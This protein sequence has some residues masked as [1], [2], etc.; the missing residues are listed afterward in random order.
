MKK[1]TKIV[2]SRS[3]CVIAEVAPRAPKIDPLTGAEMS[4]DAYYEKWGITDP[5]EA[6]AQERCIVAMACAPQEAS[7]EVQEIFLDWVDPYR[8]DADLARVVTRYTGDT[9]GTLVAEGA[10]VW[11]VTDLNTPHAR[12]GWP[13]R[14]MFRIKIVSGS[15]AAALL[16]E[17]R[18][19]AEF[20]IALDSYGI[21]HARR[22]E[23]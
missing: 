12:L 18:E 14:V 16:Q 21:S 17:D 10:C 8:G 15:Q 20:E 19:V 3:R 23:A 1:P 6:R 11:S 9:R 7:R 4:D 13:P 5:D 22:G 2:S